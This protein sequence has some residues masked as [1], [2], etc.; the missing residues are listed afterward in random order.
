LPVQRAARGEKVWQEELE[1]VFDDGHRAREINSA[2]PVTDACGHLGR[3]G[4]CFHPAFM[5]QRRHVKKRTTCRGSRWPMKGSL[6]GGVERG[7]QD[8]KTPS[9]KNGRHSPGPAV[10]ER[11]GRWQAEPP[12]GRPRR[13]G[14]RT[15]TARLLG[16]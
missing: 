3:V 9:G 13:S 4:R 14:S 5:D 8:L 15:S 2:V 12:N 11:L 6:T 10:G 7:G 1:V 16:R